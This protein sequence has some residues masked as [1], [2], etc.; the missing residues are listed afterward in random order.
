[1][2]VQKLSNIFGSYIPE[3]DD[4]DAIATI[5]FPSDSKAMTYFIQ[6]TK[7]QNRIHW[8]DHSLWQ[9]VKDAISSRINKELYYS[10]E[11]LSTFEGLKKVVLK[12]DSNYWRRLSDDKQ[13]QQTAHTLQNHTPRDLK[14]E[15]SS[16]IIS[17]DRANI[18]STT[19]TEW[20]Q[21]PQIQIRPFHNPALISILGSNR[22][23]TLSERQCHMDLG[24][25]I[26][27]GNLV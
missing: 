10:K 3:D 18:Y 21:L 26:R 4:K 13:R 19:F 25:C 12:I 11:D 7:Y 23:L 20:Y 8:G 1:M 5:S 9:V 24:L 2:F 14:P 27:Y 16:S 15:Q 17:I 6:F 22:K